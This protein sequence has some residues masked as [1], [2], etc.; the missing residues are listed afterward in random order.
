VKGWVAAIRHDQLLKTK[1]RSVR[2]HDCALGLRL[3]PICCWGICSESVA[4]PPWR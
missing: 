3:V 1:Y 4:R 2:N